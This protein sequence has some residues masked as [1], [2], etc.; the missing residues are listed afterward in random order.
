[1]ATFNENDKLP[2]FNKSSDSSQL[3]SWTPNVLDYISGDVI[4]RTKYDRKD[5]ISS[6][7]FG[8]LVNILLPEVCLV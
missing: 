7:M 4:G 6:G 5:V 3:N 1:M 2:C 8:F